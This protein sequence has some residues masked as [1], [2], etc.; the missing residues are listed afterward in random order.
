M[1]TPPDEDRKNELRRKNREI[2]F[3][4]QNYLELGEEILNDGLDKDDRTKVGTLNLF[5]RTLRFNLSDNNFPIFTHRKINTKNFIEE[6][7]FM[8]SGLTN[9]KLLEEKGVN[10]WKGNTSREFL[11]NKGLPHFPEG[12]MGKIYSH[13]FR[14]FG[15]E[16]NEEFKT[17]FDQ[18]A[19][20]V[21]LIKNDPNSRRI[22]MFSQDPSVRSESCLDACHGVVI[23]LF[24]NTK[25]NKL[26]LAV[27]CRSSDYILGVS[28]NIPFYAL[29]L[30]VIAKITR[31]EPNELIMTFN[32]LHIYKNHIEKFKNIA[33]KR[34]ISPFP[35]LIINKDINSIKD[36]EELKF[37][38]FEILDYKHNKGI[39][40]EMAV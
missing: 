13:N 19:Y 16:L 35:K 1:Y 20:V 5:V 34:E 2:N 4:E 8:M 7:I 28:I 27:T 25:E 15:G 37:E 32:D 36:I 14:N 40:Y 11:D 31:F 26:D 12:E 10:I 24:T 29:M 17:G 3:E 39:L 18:L 33:L 23:Q 30:K 21:D 6:F 38:D 9:T 22:T